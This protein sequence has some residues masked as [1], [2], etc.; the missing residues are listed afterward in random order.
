MAKRLLTRAEA[1]E[2]LS[3]TERH[4]KALQ[5]RRELL[6]TKVGHLVRY[7]V[8]VLEDYIATNTGVT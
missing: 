7:D 3:T 5:Y 2:F 1:A 4:I 8:N 6:A